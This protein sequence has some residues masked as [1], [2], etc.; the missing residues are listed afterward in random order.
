MRFEE[1]RIRRAPGAAA[2]NGEGLAAFVVFLVFMSTVFASGYFVGLHQGRG[3][4]F[5]G[6]EEELVFPGDDGSGSAGEGEEE[7]EECPD[8]TDK[9]ENRKPVWRRHYNGAGAA[10]GLERVLEIFLEHRTCL[11]TGGG[12]G[13]RAG[14]LSAGHSRG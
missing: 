13:V 12:G 9:A 2:R 14:D 10:V 8:G 4:I 6:E 1:R 3:D 7:E 11:G 5:G